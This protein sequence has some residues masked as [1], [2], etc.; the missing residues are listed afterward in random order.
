MLKVIKT[1]KLH[2]TEQ[3]VLFQELADLI[4]AAEDMAASFRQQFIPTD[5]QQELYDLITYCEA[6]EGM[7]LH[8]L[9]YGSVGSGKS[10]AALGYQLEQMLTHPGCE[11][12]G[13]RRTFGEV[14]ATLWRKALEAFQKFNIPYRANQKWT[15]IH[16]ANGSIY[17]LTSAERTATSKSDKADHLGSTEYSGAILEEA[18]EIPEEFAETLV[19]RLRQKVGVRRKVVFY[20]CNPPSKDHWI[21]RKFFVDNNP[22]DP[23]SRYRVHFMPVDRNVEHVG[24]AFID[25]IHEDY[26]DNPRLYKR[27]VD[28]QF[29]PAVKGYPIFSS[30]WREDL[31]VAETDIH[32]NWDPNS[33][34]YRCWD[35]GFIRPACVVF[36]DDQQTGQIR[37]LW[38]KLGDR[39]L[40]DAFSDDVLYKTRQL[41]PRA[42]WTDCCD[43]AGRQKRDTSEKTSIDI[44]KAKGLKPKFR[45]YSIEYGLN[46]IAEQMARLIPGRKGPV[47]G[48][49]IDP[50]CE[51]I[52]DGL[53]FGYCQDKEKFDEVKPVKDGR[54]DHCIDALRYG[55]V[56]ARRP[57]NSE[58]LL[59]SIRA[60]TKGGEFKRLVVA[61]DYDPGMAR[62]LKERKIYGLGDE[63]GSRR[64]WAPRYSFG[65]RSSY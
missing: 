60:H 52:I 62:E 49:L 12:L 20:I 8:I 54:Y 61:D 9:L 16:V 36:Q 26:A 46:I 63:Y 50:Q 42:D 14:E 32:K 17:K 30:L 6:P 59:N 48:I 7:P 53:S 40:L 37:I 28:G 5:V 51:D 34:M 24:Q 29:G 18:D 1:N 21:Y 25:S 10:T 41:F 45:I 33:P 64:D 57:S 3:D 13:A 65:K 11:I 55:L 23:K 22:H 47:S 15:T 38:C 43:P 58:F 44:L 27:M 31:H 39:I 4:E 19:G 56:F 2:V 35:F